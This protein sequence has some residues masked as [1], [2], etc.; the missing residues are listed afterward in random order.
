MPSGYAHYRFGTALL[1]TLPGD[2]RRT[3]Q[4]FRNLFDV[5]LHG[6]DFFYYY[7]PLLKSNAGFLGIRFHEQTGREFFTRVCRMLRMEKSEAGIAYLYGLLCHYCL[8]SVCHP[9][10]VRQA[11]QATH[12][13]IETEFDR[14]LLETDGKI[15]PCSQDISRHLTLTPG[16]CETVARFYPPANARNIRDSLGCMAFFVRLLAT[17]DGPRRKLLE[18]TLGLSGKELKGMLMTT[19]PNPTCHALDGQLLAL[20]E[21]AAEQFPEMLTQLQAHMAYSAPFEEEFALPFGAAA[22]KET[23]NNEV[24]T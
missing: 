12:V 9:F 7:S 5:G 17:G 1:P 21:Q 8:D 4:R 3:I 14:F 2:V 13:E 23:V 15:P 11:A 10:V 24:N 18:L 22:E 20:Y 19:K 6:P 16:E